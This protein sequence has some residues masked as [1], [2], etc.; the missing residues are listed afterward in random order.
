MARES[1]DITHPKSGPDSV[2]EPDREDHD[3][4]DAGETTVPGN[5]GTPEPS[6]PDEDGALTGSPR[7]MLD[8]AGVEDEELLEML[9]QLSDT[10]D[11]AQNA[12][13]GQHEFVSGA[14][15][16]EP[17][18]PSQF[19]PPPPPPPPAKRNR[20]LPLLAASA[21]VLL[22]VGVLAAF[23]LLWSPPSSPIAGKPVKTQDRVSETIVSRRPP[24]RAETPRVDAEPPVRTEL[25]SPSKLAS[26]APPPPDQGAPAP[27]KAPEQA[28]LAPVKAPEQTAPPPPEQAA[29]APMK[30]P[31]QAAPAPV[32]VSEPP[33]DRPAAM[34]GPSAANL[35][36][37]VE[38]AAI[39][40]EIKPDLPTLAPEDEARLLAR[41]KTL[42]AT[43]DVASARLA[44]EYAARR[45]SSGAMFALAQTY[46]PEMLAAWSVV[47]MQPDLSAAAKWY[48]RA[49]DLGHDRAGT[50]RRELEKQIGR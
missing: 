14:M 11:T 9:E 21:G 43:G 27:M 49:A 25:P 20:A 6:P 19:L 47:G 12:L 36:K 40:V 23:W 16:A 45:G 3:A 50:R 1:K 8:A 2:H 4:G 42:T 32:K 48:G 10:I 13:A 35:E 15:H 24:P 26:T 46:D 37:P 31:E 33:N 17:P 22:G 39:P 44:Y 18:A 7:A 34:A 29:P 38:L 28:A 5:A 41:G 30:P